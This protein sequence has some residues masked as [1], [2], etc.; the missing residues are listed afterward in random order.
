MTRSGKALRVPVSAKLLAVALLVCAGAP[1]R[2]VT[3]ST[4]FAV[5]ITITTSCVINSAATL[6]FGSQGVLAANVDQTATIQVQ[7]TSSTP[8][9]LRLDAG[10]SGGTVT[11]RKMTNGA[12]T[13]SYSLFRDAARTLNWGLT[14]GTDTVSGTG[15]GASQ[16]ITVYGRVPAQTTPAPAAYS[17]TVTLTVSY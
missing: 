14:D 3:T 15:N 11:T 10:T 7:C 2:A 16:S 17:D 6:S 1:A 8:Y 12:N 4:T 13:V 9:N 5:Q